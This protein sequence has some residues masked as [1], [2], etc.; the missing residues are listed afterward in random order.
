[1][2]ENEEN[3]HTTTGSGT[4]KDQNNSVNQCN[5]TMLGEFKETDMVGTKSKNARGKTQK[6]IKDKHV[7]DTKKVTF[8]GKPVGNQKH[9]KGK[10]V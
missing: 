1:M 3:Q 2:V 4:Y 6:V 9:G 10:F 7:G 5:K 8:K